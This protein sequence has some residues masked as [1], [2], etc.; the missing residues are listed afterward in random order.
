MFKCLVLA[1]D[2]LAIFFFS[3]NKKCGGKGFTVCVAA[4]SGCSQGLSSFYTFFLHH[5]SQV[6]VCPLVFKMVASGEEEGK[7]MK[8]KR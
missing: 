2:G 1:Y 7:M 3:C 6:S 8:G 5:P 4:L